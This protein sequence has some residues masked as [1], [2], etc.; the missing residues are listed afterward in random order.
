MNKIQM[1]QWGAILTDREFGKT[2]MMELRPRI[3]PPVELD[4]SG[5]ISLGSSFADEVI[6]VIA[7][8]QGNSIF[9][10]NANKPVLACLSQ[11]VKEYG[12]KM[13][14]APFSAAG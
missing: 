11:L 1:N 7:R 12:F 3:D 4:F 9:I 8:L 13:T 14:V 6:A 5:V 2:V 10:S